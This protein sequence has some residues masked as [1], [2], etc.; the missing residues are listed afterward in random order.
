[1]TPLPFKYLVLPCPPRPFS[2]ACPTHAHPPGLPGEPTL[3]P[4]H[5]PASSREVGMADSPQRH[6][7]WAFGPGKHLSLGHGGTCPPARERARRAD[8]YVGTIPALPQGA[9]SPR[10]NSLPAPKTVSKDQRANSGKEN[11][12]ISAPHQHLLRLPPSCTSAGGGTG[13][14]SLS[15]IPGLAPSPRPPSSCGAGRC[16]VPPAESPS[17]SLSPTTSAETAGKQRE[18]VKATVKLNQNSQIKYLTS[19]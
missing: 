10:S 1:M 15:C 11:A 17:P 14:P 9:T 16:P 5:P 6:Q 4:G 13:C 19:K 18:P 12:L 8:G 3:R 2:H 7:G